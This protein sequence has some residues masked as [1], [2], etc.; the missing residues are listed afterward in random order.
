MQTHTM[1]AKSTGKPSS[2]I[3]A[4]A[5]YLR[6][7]LPLVDAISNE[8]RVEM[9]KASD[10]VELLLNKEYQ[11]STNKNLPL[12][13]DERQARDALKLLQIQGL[14]KK[15]EIIGTR[16]IPL[17][18]TQQASGTKPSKISVVHPEFDISW[19]NQA[20]YIWIYEGTLFMTYFYSFGVLF[21]LLIIMLHPL[22]PYNLRLGIWYLG[23]FAFGLIGLLFFLSIIR[24]FTYVSML[25]FGKRLWIFP[26]LFE[27]VGFLDSFR[28]FYQ[29]YN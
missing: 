26:N 29:F 6:K 4:I 14:I 11:Q 20:S 24:L 10:V 21:I 28:P 1:T 19:N 7:R 23:M 3:L 8:R 25:F 5:D 16:T 9:F 13:E 2:E 27:D 22:W 18:P 15:V 17:T 12:I